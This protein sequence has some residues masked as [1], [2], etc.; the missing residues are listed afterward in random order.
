MFKMQSKCHLE[1]Q[2]YSIGAK[3]YDIFPWALKMSFKYS[4]K[5]TN[6]K[7]LSFSN[8][9]KESSPLKENCPSLCFNQE[10]KKKSH[11]HL[12][13]TGSLKKAF[14]SDNIFTSFIYIDAKG[15]SK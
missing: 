15:C 14:R 13:R 11:L 6:K 8:S 5:N 9:L 10:E 2:I 7:G 4:F 12:K 3:F 1:I